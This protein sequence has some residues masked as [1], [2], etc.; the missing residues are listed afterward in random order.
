[1]RRTKVLATARDP[2]RHD[3]P[4][5]GETSIMTHH[6]RRHDERPAEASDPPG[7]GGP[8][9]GGQSGDTQGVS[10][11]V[12]A[13][14]ESVEELASEGQGY[15]AQVLKGVEDAT[16]HPGQPVPDRLASPRR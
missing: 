5:T 16:D 14:E 12:E 13:A 1:M 9:S 15:E 10:Q 4:T 8:G 11:A 6:V 2:R 3:S 7:H